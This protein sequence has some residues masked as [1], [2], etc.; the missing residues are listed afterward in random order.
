MAD[1]TLRSLMRDTEQ[2]VKKDAAQL[3]VSD[4][5]GVC[6]HATAPLP[7]HHHRASWINWLLHMPS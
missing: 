4:D 3:E 2:F 5:D 7:Q 1:A 6:F